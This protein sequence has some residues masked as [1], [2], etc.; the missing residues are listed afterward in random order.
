MLPVLPGL[1]EVVIGFHFSSNSSFP[2][3]FKKQ[4]SVGQLERQT[5]AFR[6]GEGV[7][8]SGKQYLVYKFLVFFC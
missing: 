6:V 7:S 2:P 3:F 4:S 5:V 1:Y 8:M